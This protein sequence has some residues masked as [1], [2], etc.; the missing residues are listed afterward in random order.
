MFQN[1]PMH[2]LRL[3]FAALSASVVL[4]SD[5]H[6]QALKL[7][8]VTVT[9]HVQSTEMR[10]RREPDFSL[11]ARVQLFLMNHGDEPIRFDASTPVHVRGKT[12]DELLAADEWAWHDFPSAWTNEPLVLPPE[13]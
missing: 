12:P 11:G 4:A 7:V 6:S 1:I 8:G 5:G 9:P 13:A 10:Y 3:R 2:L